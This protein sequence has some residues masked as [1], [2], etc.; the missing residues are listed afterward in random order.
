MEELKQNT[1]KYDVKHVCIHDDTFTANPK[2]VEEFCEVYRKE[3]NLP[4]YCFAYPTTVKPNLIKAMRAANCNTIFLGLDSGSE[5]IRAN[6]MER[7]MPDQL[8]QKSAK[9]I[10]DTGIGLQ[11][12]CMYGVP[13]ETEEQMYKTLSMIEEI[14]PRQSSGYVFYPLPKTRMYEAAVKLGYLDEEGQEK[15]R[16]GI[17]S[18]HHESI[19]KH[20]HKR[21]AETLAAITPVYVASPNAAKPFLKWVIKY[22]IK[23]LA[24]FLYLLMIPIMF[25]HLGWEGVKVTL[26]MAYRSLFGRS[27]S[28]NARARIDYNV[29]Y[30]EQ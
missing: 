24:R 6:L 12:S 25:P 9:I 20:P 30:A 29:Q 3:I 1:A 15:A 26:R 8:I 13:G 4:W 19:L 5:E 17:S 7:P 2:W 21:L 16:Q 10:T 14:K 18:F 11:V 22:R 23:W 27:S 28:K